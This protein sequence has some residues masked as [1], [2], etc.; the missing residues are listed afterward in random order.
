MHIFIWLTT[1]LTLV[2]SQPLF[3]LEKQILYGFQDPD[4][5]QWL[6]E[7]QILF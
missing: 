7:F 6:P 4:E 2:I 1:L 5:I 3:G